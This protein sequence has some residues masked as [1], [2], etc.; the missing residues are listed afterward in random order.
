M[1]TFYARL[2]EKRQ[3]GDELAA[4][5]ERVINQLDQTS[6]TSERPG[7]LLGKIQSGKTRGFLG[8]IARA[9]D[10]GYEIAIVLTKGTKTLSQQTVARIAADFADFVNDDEVSIF[11]IMK[12]PPR[13]T[14]SERLRKLVIVAKKQVKNLERLLRLFEETYPDLRERRTLLI[15]DEADLASV[16]FVKNKETEEIDQGRIAGQMDSLRK[17]IPRIAFLQV[18]ATPY[19]LYLQPENYEVTTGQNYV[20]LP[21][22]PAFTELLPIHGVYVGGADF[23]GDYEE[24]DPR[25][26]LHVNVPIEEQ[27]ILRHP[28]GRSARDDHLLTTKNLECLRRAIL[29]FL[30]AVSIR[31]WQQRDVGERLKKYA[32]IIH[33]DTRKQAHKWQVDIVQRLLDTFVEA[34]RSGDLIFRKQLAACLI[35]LQQSVQADHGRMP[36][37]KNVIETVADALRSE[38]VV[39]IPVNSDTDVAALLDEKAELRL[40]TPFNVFVGGNILDRGIT[41]PNM[42]GFYYGR[43]PK[44]MQADT[45]LQHSRMYG[46][47]D[48]RDL[49]VT[50]F[51][52]SQPVFDRLGRIEEFEIALRNAFETGAHDRGVAFIRLDEN[53][54]VIPCAPGKIMLSDVVAVRPGGRLLPVGFQSRAKTHIESLVEEIDQLIPAE[55][56]DTNTPVRVSLEALHKIIDLVEQTMDVGETGWDWGGFRAALDYFSR[57]SPVPDERE[58]AWFLALK[59]R[60]ISRVRTGGRFQNA[61]DTKQQRDTAEAYARTL[62]M[63]M[64]FRLEGTKDQGWAGYPFWWPVLVAPHDAA[65]CVYASREASID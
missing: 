48:R 14:K 36:Q 5:I 6:T 38:E 28:D 8:V 39:V 58:N 7:M 31:R 10:R 11:D 26:Y 32:L 30:V 23:F 50:R 9:F 18:T 59:D 25:S 12:L 43:H 62:P 35:D 44:R 1:S 16:R 13:L 65:P 33:N 15:D 60:A 27:D 3:D 21:K 4:C 41:I 19:A 61:P 52:T 64:L 17:L 24:D 37:L 53:K 57:T 56:A 20:F 29:T 47:R 2:R 54:T 49:A 40:R 63:L 55:C 34:I 22:R 42:I 46:A 51:Y 45:V